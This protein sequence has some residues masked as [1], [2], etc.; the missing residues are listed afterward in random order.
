[1]K[2]VW[3][4]AA[5]SA[6][7]LAAP[8]KRNDAAPTATDN[9]NWSSLGQALKSISFT[10]PT[11]SANLDNI[12]PPPRS[13]IPEIVKNVPP[14]ALAQLV[15]P[16]QRSSLASE[17]QAG[18]TPSWYNALPSDIKSYMAQVKKEMSDGAL[19]ATTGKYA[20]AKAT[21][22]STKDG[23][24]SSTTS[25]GMGAA[26]AQPTGGLVLG[27]MGALGVLGVALAL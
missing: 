9:V 6:T 8:E 19:T 27:G 24:A 5:L 14:S 21:A 12:S 17:I 16:A 25:S 26:G 10:M 23:G 11:G 18:H 15:V 2:F 20:P 13:L 1:M 4:L 3:L 22:E 7:V